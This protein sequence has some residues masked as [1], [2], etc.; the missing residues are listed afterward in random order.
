M[1]G[2]TTWPAG[3][4]YVVA[5]A[6]V[7]CG[8]TLTIAAGAVVKFQPGGLLTVRGSLVVEGGATP[9][10]L[11]S[12]RDDRAGGDTNGDGDATAPSPGDWDG[13]SLTGGACGG[14]PA[15][16]L[17][18]GA[19]LRFGGSGGAALRA[20]ES[21]VG[22][23]AVV[24][25]QG[26]VVE[27]SAGTGVSGAGSSR[28][29]LTLDAVT[30]SDNGGAGVLFRGRRLQVSSSDVVRNGGAGVQ[31]L[32]PGG[33][34]ITESRLA[35]NGR[36]TP[37]RGAELCYAPANPII[38]FAGNQVTGNSRGGVAICGTVQGD[39][40]WS[41]LGGVPYVLSST[42]VVP[43][44]RRLTLPAGAVVK[45]AA[46]AF[47]VTGQL[48]L[49]GEGGA[50]EL[51]SLYDDSV[52]GCVQDRCDAGRRTPAP[53]D[54]SVARVRR[55]SAAAGQLSL[56][57]ARVRYAG[58]RFGDGSDA[59]VLVR[60]SGLGGDATAGAGVTAGVQPAVT[61]NG[62]AFRDIRGP[63]IRVDTAGSY[64]VH[65]VAIEQVSQDAAILVGSFQATVDATG[66][67][68]GSASGP[69]AAPGPDG[70][71]DCYTPPDVPLETS[72]GV[73]VGCQVR[74]VPFLTAPP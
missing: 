18:H 68:W 61:W 6:T 47:D 25:D 39:Q 14:A 1:L 27:R 45:S 51:T 40:V 23:V 16:L 29:D 38:A 3:P 10:V 28:L 9:V 53:G 12:L 34:A 73:P 49:G 69:S 32:G 62:G 42:V 50:I 30:I 20:T 72:T 64:S 36:A 19:R 15:S 52:G 43:A 58:D 54:W 48:E 57:G 24:L 56:A 11:T 65:R 17:L 70:P 67:W 33:F 41:A 26:S 13:V 22:G 35:D 63:G 60:S 7:D 71:V 44:G 66:N 55:T 5:R 21:G 46:L 59:A 8:A 4:V 74:F 31:L 2:T 37:A